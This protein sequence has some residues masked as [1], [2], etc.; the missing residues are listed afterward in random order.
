MERLSGTAGKVLDRVTGWLA[1]VAGSLGAAKK[2][3]FSLL[4]TSLVL[5]LGSFSLVLSLGSFSFAVG[6]GSFGRPFFDFFFGEDG[7][8]SSVTFLFDELSF[9]I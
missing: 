7:E 6:F 1:I 2:L 8:D 5:A 4:G 3:N 9:S